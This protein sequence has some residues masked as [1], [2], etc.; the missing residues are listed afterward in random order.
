MLCLDLLSEPSNRVA[1]GV[2]ATMGTIALRQVISRGMDPNE[3]LAGGWKAGKKVGIHMLS[4]Q[5]TGI[6]ELS[7]ALQGRSSS[8]RDP[9]WQHDLGPSEL[10]WHLI[11][12]LRI[13]W[14]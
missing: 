13:V 14:K 2:R 4:L 5:G 1:S 9:G 8:E 10:T 11:R 3:M 6:A 12:H 7:P